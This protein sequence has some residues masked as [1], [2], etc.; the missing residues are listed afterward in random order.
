MPKSCC[1]SCLLRGSLHYRYY[2]IHT[3]MF[4]S[5]FFK[6]IIKSFPVLSIVQPNQIFV[7]FNTICYKEGSQTLFFKLKSGKWMLPVASFNLYCIQKN[8]L[9]HQTLSFSIVALCGFCNCVLLLP[10]NDAQITCLFVPS[11][12]YIFFSSFWMTSQRLEHCFLGEISI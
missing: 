5:S 7:F 9:W 8:L 6:A 10:S 3:G 2:Q 1:T 4:S 11:Y 12:F